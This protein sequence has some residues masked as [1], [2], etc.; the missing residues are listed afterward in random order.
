M[1]IPMRCMNCGFVLADKW[2]WYQGRIA[3]L[4]KTMGIGQNVLYITGKE[5]PDTPERK[6][7]DELGIT[8]YCCRKHLLTHRDLLEK[9]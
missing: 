7:M 5:V 3:E 9:I 1:I 8:R 4:R 6:A 2:L